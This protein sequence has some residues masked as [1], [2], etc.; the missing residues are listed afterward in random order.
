M[1]I[2]EMGADDSFVVVGIQD[3]EAMS[4]WPPWKH[5]LEVSI[6]F[7]EFVKKIDMSMPFSTK[8]G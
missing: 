2:R 6:L 1:D 8:L 4:A 3:A 7:H 5:L